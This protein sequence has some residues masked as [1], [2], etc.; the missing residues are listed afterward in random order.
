[1]ALADVLF[2]TVDE[3]KNYL[4]IR[5]QSND[6]ELIQDLIDSAIDIAEEHMNR[7]WVVGDVV[8]SPI[9][10][11]CKKMIASW[12]EHR[13]DE[14]RLERIGDTTT[15]RDKVPWTAERILDKYRLNSGL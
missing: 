14:T 12:Y 4:R 11:A 6:D 9:K 7:P 10:L 15:H 5:Y 2:I 8:P 13:D 1:M 3:M